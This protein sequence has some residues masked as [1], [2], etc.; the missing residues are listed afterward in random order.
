M[1]PNMP[2][3][4]NAHQAVNAEETL[5]PNYSLTIPRTNPCK[6]KMSSA[7]VLFKLKY[8]VL[9]IQFFYR[10][11]EVIVTPSLLNVH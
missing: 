9:N 6:F 7:L 5:S 10:N 4:K 11:Q 3:T 1:S 8:S 2:K